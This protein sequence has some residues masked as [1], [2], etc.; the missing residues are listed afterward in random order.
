MIP[1]QIEATGFL[2]T[3][4]RINL[5]PK[6]EEYMELMQKDGVDFFSKM[7]WV[8][9]GIR[10]LPGE[11]DDNVFATSQEDQERL[12]LESLLQT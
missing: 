2:G 10:Y 9:R 3:T 5:P 1:I 4:K 8:D 12:E 7:K 11:D 6:F